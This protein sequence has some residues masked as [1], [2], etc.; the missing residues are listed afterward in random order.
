MTLPQAIE[1]CLRER[2]YVVALQTEPVER[3]V[4]HSEFVPQE[5]TKPLATFTY[6]CATGGIK[7]SYV[8]QPDRVL[9]LLMYPAFLDIKFPGI[10]HLSVVDRRIGKYIKKRAAEI[11][12]DGG[13]KNF[14]E[15]F[16]EF[17]RD[18]GRF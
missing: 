18:S 8:S 5:G 1:K 3:I 14:Y 11:G 17:W 2:K 13:P 4:I 7:V 16:N 12:R 15:A 9:S 6:D 10:G